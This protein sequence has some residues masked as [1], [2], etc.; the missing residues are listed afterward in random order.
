MNLY[1]DT[2]DGHAQMDAGLAAASC[3]RCGE[4][5][6]IR[7]TISTAFWGRDGLVVI[8]NI[9]ALVCAGCG[10]E[11]I[12]DDTAVALDHMRGGGFDL[13]RATRFLEVPVFRFAGTRPE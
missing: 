11:H 8:E 10:E 3:S 12:A 4:A 9:P 5:R 2:L 13:E 7:D 1:P 6:L